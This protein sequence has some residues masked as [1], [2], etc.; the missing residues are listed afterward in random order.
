[1]GI[2]LALSPL[3]AILSALLA[4]VTAVAIAE[5]RER[6]GDWPVRLLVWGFVASGLGLSIAVDLVNLQGD[7][8]RM[9]T[10]F[11]FYLQ[12]W[13]LYA[14]AAVFSLSLIVPAVLRRLAGP[15]PPRAALLTWPIF[16]AI[17]PSPALPRVTSR[18]AGRRDWKGWDVVWLGVVAFLIGAS[19]IYPVAATPVRVADRFQSLPW[20]NDGAAFMRVSQYRDENRLIDLAADLQAIEWLWANVDGSPVI[21]EAVTPLYRW[22]S[23]VSVYTGLPA[24]VGWDW[25]QKQQRWGYRHLVETRLSDVSTLFAS[26]DAGVAMSILRQYG[27]RYVYVGPVEKAYYPAVGLSKFQQ[28]VGRGLRVAYD[29]RGVTI[30]EVTPA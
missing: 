6:R 16:G 7:I 10:V 24:I 18:A 3:L 19:V 28:L 11:K 5:L 8:G 1:G 29:D 27:V 9:N 2:A 26:P 4:L 13:V 25:H 20:T 22:G 23:R 14:L 30:Y 21:A 17:A 12:I 15:L